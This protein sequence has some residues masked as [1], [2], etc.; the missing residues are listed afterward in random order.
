MPSERRL[1]RFAPTEVEDALRR[2]AQEQQRTMPDGK[3]T[4][5]AYDVE[6]DEGVSARV[7]FE[8][9]KPPMHFTALEMAAAL[10]AYCRKVQ[11]PIP[12]QGQKSLHRHND[13]LVLQ[14]DVKPR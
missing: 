6:S 3:V 13:T 8:D 1:I 14:I 4:G 9:V 10:I 12:K 2:F 7:Q 11:V 5:I